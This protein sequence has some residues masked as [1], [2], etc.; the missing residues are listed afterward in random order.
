MIKF[1][2]QKQAEQK[3]VDRVPTQC[4][5]AVAVVYA[6][7]VIQRETYTAD[8]TARNSYT[9]TTLHRPAAPA[10]LYSY[11]TLYTI[12]PYSAIQYTRYTSS[13]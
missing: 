9:G 2:E 7:E 12:H 4:C 8:Y 6:V 1:Y 5:T 11:T 3:Q 10:Q 13:L